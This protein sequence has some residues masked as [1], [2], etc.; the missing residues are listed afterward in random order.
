MNPIIDYISVYIIY[1]PIKQSLNTCVKVSET[2]IDFYAL[3]RHLQT[4]FSM[5]NVIMTLTV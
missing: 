4:E 2:I 1:D 3:R 5:L